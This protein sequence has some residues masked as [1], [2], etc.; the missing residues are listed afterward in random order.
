MFELLDDPTTQEPTEADRAAVV[1]AGRNRLTR[2]RLLLGGSTVSVLLVAGTVGAAV[3][4]NDDTPSVVRTISS[5]DSTTTTTNAPMVTSVSTT[6]PVTSPSTTQPPVTTA[7][8]TTIPPRVEPVATRGGRPSVPPRPG[9]KLTLRL[10]RTVFS[11]RE[12]LLGVLTIENTSE[13]DVSIV[14]SDCDGYHQGIYRLGH[15]VG[16][17][18]DFACPAVVDPVVVSPGQ[19]KEVSV[20]IDALGPES[21][22]GTRPA[23]APGVYQAAAGIYAAQGDEQQAWF[24]PSVDVRIR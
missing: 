6:T 12:K 18:P 19:S 24:A 22:D 1:S 14:P 9:V 5:P 23:L 16:G 7:P 21:N 15:W 3:L 4:I 17:R 2:R 11:A 8:T 10:D 13:E 20:E